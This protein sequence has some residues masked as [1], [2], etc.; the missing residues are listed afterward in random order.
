MR[1]LAGVFTTLRFL[2]YGEKLQEEEVTRENYYR[3]ERTYGC[4]KRS[5]NLSDDVL[6]DDVDAS[7]KDGILKLTLKKDNTKEELKQITIN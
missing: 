6:I 2:F 4:F 5:F 1:L 7:F 3:R